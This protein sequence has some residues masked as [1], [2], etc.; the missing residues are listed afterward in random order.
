MSSMEEMRFNRRGLHIPQ[1]LDIM[2]YSILT[3][4][5]VF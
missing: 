2:V 5:V 1:L 4:C 3:S